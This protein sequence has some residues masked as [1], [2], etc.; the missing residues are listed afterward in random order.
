MQMAAPDALDIARE[1]RAVQARYGVDDPNCAS[2]GRQCLMARRLVERGVRFVQV[3]CPSNRISGGAV[4]DVPWDGH[5]DILTN[6]RDCG[7]MTDR[8]VAGLLADLKARG[9]LDSTLVIWGGEFGRTSDS[10]G[11][12]GRDHNPQAYTTILA[13]G[14]ARG[15]V[16]YGKT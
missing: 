3:F 10:Q 4:G 16:H 12:K 5:S 11:S 15:G 9:L 13:G 14:G 7:L 2:F 8:P 6:H 1:P